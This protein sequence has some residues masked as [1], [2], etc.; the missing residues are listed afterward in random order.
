[1]QI[2]ISKPENAT[3]RAQRKG[4]EVSGPLA[5]CCWPSQWDAFHYLQV[6]LPG[7]PK[8]VLAGKLRVRVST[9][10]S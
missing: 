1:M 8:H 6:L 5:W 2:S 7:G 10:S 4:L 3:M 9:T